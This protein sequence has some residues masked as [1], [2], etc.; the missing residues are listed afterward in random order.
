VDRPQQIDVATPS[1]RS[2]KPHAPLS[3]FNSR[4]RRAALRQTA[5]CGFS[6]RCISSVVDARTTVERLISDE[7][8]ALPTER[9]FIYSKRKKVLNLFVLAEG[10][11]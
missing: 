8:V 4:L 6:R 9:L 10:G 2:E 11:I 3:S 5:V 1:R 7:V